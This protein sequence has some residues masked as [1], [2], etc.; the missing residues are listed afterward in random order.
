MIYGV[1][2][3]LE[4]LCCDAYAILKSSSSSLSV[5]SVTAT[6]Q[7]QQP[8]HVRFEEGEEMETSVNEEVVQES[9][10]SPSCSLLRFHNI[11]LIVLSPP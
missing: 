6:A 3:R 9:S 5:A 2:N 1:L 7:D 8:T 4:I 10:T 11:D